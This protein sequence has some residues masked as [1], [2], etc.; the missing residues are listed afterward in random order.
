MDQRD[1]KPRL[2][3]KGDYISLPTLRNVTTSRFER[4]RGTP[5]VGDIWVPKT[6]ILSNHFVNFL[7]PSDKILKVETFG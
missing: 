7:I 6:I 2:N 3:F 5:K 1:G 4:L